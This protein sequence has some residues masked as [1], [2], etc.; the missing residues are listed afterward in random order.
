MSESREVA[1]KP[2]SSASSPAMKREF[3]HASKYSLIVG[4]M[5]VIAVKASDGVGSN[6]CGVRVQGVRLALEL[7]QRRDVDV[8]VGDALAE[9]DL[10][11]AVGVLLD[12]GEQVGVGPVQRRLGEEEQ[13]ARLLQRLAVRQL[14]AE[15][16]G[17]LGIGGVGAG[18]DVDVVLG[19]ARHAG[20]DALHLLVGGVGRDE[21]VLRLGEQRAD[22]VA[23][24]LQQRVVVEVGRL[25]ERVVLLGVRGQDVDLS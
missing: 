20:D 5:I 13:V 6:A 3:F 1:T 12:V 10:A 2:C 7:A 4:V 17:A 24:L 23:V 11:V 22:L 16:D 14:E 9:L 25:G 18:V 21:G 19:E 8:G 15:R